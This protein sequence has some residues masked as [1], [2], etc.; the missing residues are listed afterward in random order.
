[1]ERGA[2]NTTC[3]RLNLDTLLDIGEFKSSCVMNEKHTF[4]MPNDFGDQST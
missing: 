3:L 2:V 4:K 1:M